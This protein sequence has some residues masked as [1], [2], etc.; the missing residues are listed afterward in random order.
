ML[1]G[2]GGTEGKLTEL[3]KNIHNLIASRETSS[4]LYSRRA[5]RANCQKIAQKPDA[6]RTLTNNLTDSESKPSI[7]DDCF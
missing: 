4:G 3:A 1:K 5:G 6:N 2:T 7:S